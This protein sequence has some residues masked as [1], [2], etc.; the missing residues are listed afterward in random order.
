MRSLSVLKYSA[1]RFIRLNILLLLL[2]AGNAKLYANSFEIWTF[3][4][5]GTEWENMSFYLGSANFFY[6][7]GG[8]FL[9]HTQVSFNF[10]TKKAVSYGL[11]YKQEY[12]KILKKTRKEYRPMLHLYY[13]KCFGHFEFKDRNRMEF[14]IFNSGTICRYRKRLSLHYTK[15]NFIKPYVS[16]ESFFYFNEINFARQ[17]TV[18]GVEV[19]IRS[20]RLNVFGGHQT[21]K[22][23]T[24]YWHH[25]FMA[26][27]SLSYSF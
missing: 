12:V 11:A 6:A 7:G 16:T 24:G 3:V 19:P 23:T 27:T 14:R 13:S 8:W 9:N 21:D 5:A 1:Q 18:L 22:I 2:L 26:G 25:R 17:R 10:A 20:L 4:G 15:I